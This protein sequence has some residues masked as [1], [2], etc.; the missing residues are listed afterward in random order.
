M[1]DFHQ[2]GLRH[3][4]LLDF[5]EKNPSKRPKCLSPTSLSPRFTL[6][7]KRRRKKKRKIWLILQHRSRRHVQNR[8]NAQN[9]RPDLMNVHPVW[10]LKT[11]L[12]KLALK[13]SWTFTIV[14]IIV[15][16]KISSLK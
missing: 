1:G 4:S 11:R 16:Q 13:R 2:L 12:Q 14:W 6:R 8:L 5:L 3:L 7:K 10:N 15:L 9:T